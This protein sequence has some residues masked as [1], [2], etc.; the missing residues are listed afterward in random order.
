M[1]DDA[2]LAARAADGDPGAFGRLVGQYAPVAR[3]MARALLGSPEDADDA[4]QD[5]FLAAWR[6]IDRYDPDRPF[7]PWLLRIVLNAARDLGRRRVVRRTEA[8]TPGAVEQVP[9]AGPTPEQAAGRVLLRE[10]LD[11]ALAALPERQRV[12]VTLFDGEG[13]AHSE[14]AS[15][16]GVPEGTVRSDLFHGRRALRAALRPFQEDT[17][18]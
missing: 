14:I 1:T 10:A 3:R 13:Y 2:E 6:A 4:V 12:A 7:R 18:A 16:L 17:R 15:L 8:L 11:R 9:G 5:G